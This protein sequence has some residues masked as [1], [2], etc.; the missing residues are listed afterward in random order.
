MIEEDGCSVATLRYF[1]ES[2]EGGRVFDIVGGH[3]LAW[4][5]DI[6]NFTPTRIIWL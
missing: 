2:I 5:D 4:K 3:T 1:G 6:Y